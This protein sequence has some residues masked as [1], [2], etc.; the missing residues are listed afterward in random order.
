MDSL[1]TKGE[2]LSVQSNDDRFDCF[3]PLMF[4]SLHADVTQGHLNIIRAFSN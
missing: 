1:D 3:W 4:L 2:T